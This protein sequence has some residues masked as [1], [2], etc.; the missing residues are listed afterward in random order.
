MVARFEDVL[1][2]VENTGVVDPEEDENGEELKL[3]SDAWY[4]LPGID[5]PWCDICLSYGGSN[6]DL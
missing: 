3:G 1:L 5:M 6:T 4:S 2:G